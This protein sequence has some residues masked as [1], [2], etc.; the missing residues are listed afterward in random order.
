MFENVVVGIGDYEGGRDAAELATALVS[1]DGEI[2]LVYV[3][4]LQSDPATDSGA[5]PDVERQRFGLERLRRL[6]DVAQIAAEVARIQAPS[7]R[8]GLLGLP[9]AELPT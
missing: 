9:P 5:G 7:V 3:E 1:S 2:T 6:R 8:H 4:G